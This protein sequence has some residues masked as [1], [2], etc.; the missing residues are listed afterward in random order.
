MPVI[1]PSA[2][3]LNT[4]VAVTLLDNGLPTSSTAS[5]CG[6]VIPGAVLKFFCDGP[7]I[8]IFDILVALGFA[9]GV[10]N[11]SLNPEPLEVMFI[12][13]SSNSPSEFTPIVAIGF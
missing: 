1:N 7:N 4:A 12:A 13:S 5:G 2:S 10:A 9:A 8:F 11:S 3:I 6:N